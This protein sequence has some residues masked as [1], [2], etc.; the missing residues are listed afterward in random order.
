MPNGNR[1][2]ERD[3]TR[4]KGRKEETQ[5]RRRMSI[6]PISPATIVIPRNPG[7]GW[8]EV[9]DGVGC[10]VGETVSE[11]VPGAVVLIR[12]ASVSSIPIGGVTSIT[13]VEMG[14]GPAII[15]LPE[16]ALALAWPAMKL[17]LMAEPSLRP[18]HVKYSPGRRCSV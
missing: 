5:V 1:N 18:F 13:N 6:A 9:V 3:R 16:Q 8:A 10:W 17:I 4:K 7:V 14:C 2:K 15:I 11:D 12:V